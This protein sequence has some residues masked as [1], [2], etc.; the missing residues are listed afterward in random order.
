MPSTQTETARETQQDKEFND[1]S[2]ADMGMPADAVASHRSAAATSGVRAGA[3]LNAPALAGDAA[4]F[5]ATACS[6]FTMAF[7]EVGAPHSD[8]AKMTI[9]TTT[10]DEG[11][12]TSDSNRTFLGTSE[13]K[14]TSG[15]ENENQKGDNPI[16]TSLSTCTTD[17]MIQNNSHIYGNYKL[18]QPNSLLMEALMKL[19]NMG[20]LDLGSLEGFPLLKDS[21]LLSNFYH[22]LT[23]LAVGPQILQNLDEVAKRYNI[24][25]YIDT[26]YDIDEPIYLKGKQRDHVV[27]KPRGLLKPARSI[28]KMDAVDRF[29]SDSN[30]EWD[31]IRAGQEKERPNKSGEVKRQI[32]GSLELE[33]K[34]THEVIDDY[35]KSAKTK[36][37]REG[38]KVREGVKDLFAPNSVSSSFKLSGKGTGG[39]VR[40]GDRDVGESSVNNDRDRD[41]K[42]SDVLTRS[43]DFLNVFGQEDDELPSKYDEFKY[44]MAVLGEVRNFKEGDSI[45][46]WLEY[47]RV[48]VKWLKFSDE[49]IKVFV[50]GHIENFRLK[51]SVANIMTE[52]EYSS[53]EELLAEISFL[54]GAKSMAILKAEGR[55]L[56]RYDGETV[57]FFALRVQKMITK[58]VETEPMSEILL[59]SQFVKDEA[60]DIFLR[61]LRSTKFARV[62]LEEEAKTVKEAVKV[63]DSFVA[64]EVR[65]EGLREKMNSEQIPIRVDKELYLNPQREKL[66]CNNML[67]LNV[68]GNVVV[69]KDKISKKQSGHCKETTF[70]LN[71]SGR[72]PLCNGCGSCSSHYFSEG[73]CPAFGKKCGL[74]NKKG[75]LRCMCGSFHALSK[76]TQ[77]R[78]LKQ[79]RKEAFFG[80]RE[81]NF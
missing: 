47:M 74:C 80:K 41:S 42:E 72:F 77:G 7:L 68:A 50:Y 64:R 6:T 48:I 14:E 71:E 46:D 70:P 20:C 65:L 30:L 53:I 22:N 49:E 32:G 21:N 36:G 56:K 59:E 37:A 9:T 73:V 2:A 17:N 19:G 55:N 18:H 13:K 39:S 67:E 81:S 26:N 51:A 58:R 44:R 35:P 40:G 15:M 69:D 60:L 12:N 10:N 78:F 38:G 3:G 29:A 54:L 62:V 33:R 8:C 61:G 79:Q 52:K 45:S 75:H 11:R 27:G 63:I 24:V 66:V 23:K 4:V 25:R 1:G 34:L 31:P 57:H 28:G 5:N 16:E 76:S 43:G